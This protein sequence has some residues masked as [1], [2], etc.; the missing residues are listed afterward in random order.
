MRTARPFATNVKNSFLHTVRKVSTVFAEGVGRET[1][2]ESE[3]KMP[4]AGRLSLRPAPGIHSTRLFDVLLQQ[5]VADMAQ[6]T[7]SAYFQRT[8]SHLGNAGRG[9]FAGS[10]PQGLRRGHFCQAGGG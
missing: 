10:I 4:G 9:Q 6:D 2:M 1:V 7:G 5:G 8:A 3:E